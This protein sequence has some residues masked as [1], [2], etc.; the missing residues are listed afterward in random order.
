MELFKVTLEHKNVGAYEAWEEKL[1]KGYPMEGNSGPPDPVRTVY[2]AAVHGRYG[3]SM[4]ESAG[5]LALETVV[6]A[7]EHW[8][9]Y[10]AWIVAV[11]KIGGIAVE[12]SGTLQECKEG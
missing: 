12:P 7:K 2:Y 10:E 1:K 6:G 11:E 4:V 8:E 3:A 9:K 5:N